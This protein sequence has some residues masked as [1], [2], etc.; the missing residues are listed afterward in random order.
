MPR[1]CQRVRLETGLK[2]DL[3]R[4]VR[5]GFIRPGEATGPIGIAWHNNYF[6]EE[7]ASGFITADMS[8]PGIGWFRV[9]LTRGLD[10]RIFLVNR[11]RHFG[12]RQWYFQCPYLSCRATVLWKPP[13]A[14]DFACRE[15]WGCRVAYASQFMGRVDRA[16][17]GQAKIKS[18]LCSMGGFNPDEWELPPKPKWMR[19]KTYNRAEAKFDEYEA[20]L[21]EGIVAL[22]A[23]F[24]GSDQK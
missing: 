10:Q 17:R 23:R 1:Q 11:P 5:N 13:G 6:D 24:I 8:D 15:K 22:M 9:R 7:I 4:L 19:M 12:G 2:L 20:V 21:N 3:N 16:H 18:R 14:R